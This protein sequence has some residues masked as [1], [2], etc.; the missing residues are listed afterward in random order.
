MHC[1]GG[2]FLLPKMLNVKLR[3]RLQ[4]LRSAAG[5]GRSE[6]GLAQRSAFA[7]IREEKTGIARESVTRLTMPLVQAGQG[8]AKQILR[9][10]KIEDRE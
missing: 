6:Q 2:A 9:R 4:R 5:G 8:G 10:T 7:G 3:S 1:S